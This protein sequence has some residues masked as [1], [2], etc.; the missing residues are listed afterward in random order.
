MVLEPPA[1]VDEPALPVVP[2][3]PVVPVCAEA[4]KARARPR[5]IA[6]SA[7]C[8]VTDADVSCFFEGLVNLAFT[9]NCM[10]FAGMGGKR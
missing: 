5:T 6:D 9:V 4:P 3:V 8:R 2:V 7:C 10:P 1:V